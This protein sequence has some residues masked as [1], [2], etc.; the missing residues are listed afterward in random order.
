MKNDGH[1]RQVTITQ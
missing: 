1:F